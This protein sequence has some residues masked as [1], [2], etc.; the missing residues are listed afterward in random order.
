VTKSTT[1]NT[2]GKP[3]CKICTKEVSIQYMRSHVAVHI[4]KDETT[5]QVCGFCGIL[6]SGNV[7]KVNTKNK[8][9][10][11]KVDCQYHKEFSYGS[12]VKL[13]NPSSSRPEYCNIS[14]SCLW[15]YKML[16]HYITTTY[17]VHY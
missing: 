1:T 12:V 6:N 2:L 3:K 15:S 4:L 9:F 11:S 16:L 17:R 10:K 8:T 14:K 13:T 7:K 5:R